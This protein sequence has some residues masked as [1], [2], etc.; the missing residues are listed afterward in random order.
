MA[1][2]AAI[3]IDQI[4][5]HP[6]LVT[7]R[8]SLDDSASSE[9]LVCRPLAA[10][11]VAALLVFFERLSPATRRFA[12]YPSYDRECAEEFCEETK[13]PSKLRMAV[14][15]SNDDIIALFEFDCTLTDFDIERYRQHG[16]EL[17]GKTD[18]Q[19]A[20]CVADEYQ[21]KG[22]GSKLLR[23]MIDLLR[24]LGKKRILLWSGVLVDNEQAI[25]FYRRN[26]FQMFAEKFIAEDGYEC[27][28][29]ILSL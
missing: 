2:I 17:D 13:D 1:E 19:L 10:D 8:F 22:L 16:I 20:P 9:E 15:N 25:H 14:T 5:D 28:D 26:H 3:T 6:S 18:V 23:L 7:K 21:N 27:Y 4:I 29:G 11:D 12:T 24:R